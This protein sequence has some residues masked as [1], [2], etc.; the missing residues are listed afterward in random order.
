MAHT[1][2]DI[3][4]AVSLASLCLCPHQAPNIMKLVPRI[5]R[6]L[7]RTLARGLLFA[8]KG[9]LQVEIYTD[10]IELGMSLIGHL[11]L[12]IMHL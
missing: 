1:K 7:K 12:V 9:H 4:F 5:L 10:A 6:Y 3:S 2:P 11:P 8:N